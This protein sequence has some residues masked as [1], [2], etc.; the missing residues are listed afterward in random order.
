MRRPLVDPSHQ[1]TRSGLRTL[2]F[3]LIMAGAPLALVGFVSFFGAMSGG[4]APT[5]FWCAFLGLPLLGIGFF[6]LKIGYLGSIVRYVANETAPV[7]ADTTDY[8]AKQ[9]RGAVRTTVAAIAEGLRA[10]TVARACPQC[11]A[12]QRD[13]ANFCDRCGTALAAPACPKCHAELAKDA[14]FCN[15]CGAAAS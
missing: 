12:P 7:A 6:C 4:G 13:D 2:G 9:T 8:M 14:R 1:G 3:L 11:R 10:G 5:Y 15:A